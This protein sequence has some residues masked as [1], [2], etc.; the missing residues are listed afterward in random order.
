LSAAVAIYGLEG[1]SN[2]LAKSEI[3][4]REQTVLWWG[5]LRGSVSIA[6]ALSLPA[7]LPERDVIID[8]V[9]GVVLFTLLVQGLTTQLLLK[10]LGLTGGDQPLRQQYLEAVARRIALNRVINYLSQ[11]DQYQEIA[12]EFC[13]YKTKLVQGQ[14][15]SLEEEITHLQNQYPQLRALVLEQLQDKLLN[16]EAD[17]YAELIRAGRLDNKLSP[18]L[19]EVLAAGEEN[20]ID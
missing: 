7:A 1:L 16:I 14:L 5:G 9:F 10:Q 19:E 20:L 3:G 8:I 11:A 6:L 13:R 4:L 17:T 18:L 12:P 15:K 2:W